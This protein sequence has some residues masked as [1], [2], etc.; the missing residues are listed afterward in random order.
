MAGLLSKFKMDKDLDHS[1]S[2]E[3]GKMK[4]TQSISP[5]LTLKGCLCP[6]EK[7]PDPGLMEMICI[8]KRQGAGG[9]R[10]AAMENNPTLESVKKNLKAHLREK[11]TCIYEG[12]SATQSRLENIYTR[13]F[14]TQQNE[15]YGCRSHEILDQFKVP[16]KGAQ[17]FLY[18]EIDSLNIFKQGRNFFQQQPAP[19][20]SIQR[21]MTKGIAGI[22]KTVAVQNF[23]LHWAQ[24]KSNQHIDFIFVL[25][26]RELN[27]LKEGEYTLLEL[28]LH[29]YPELRPLKDAQKLPQKQVLFILDG[30]D[31]SRFSLDFEGAMTITNPDQ[32]ATVNVLLTNLLKGNL[33]PDAL[34][35]I[36]SRPAAAG[37][38]PSKYI[39]QMTE[40]QGFT[41]QH[42]EEYFKK[43]FNSAGQA[44]E[45]LD[46]LRGMIS[47]Y[48][49][50]HIPIFCWI[51]AEV[52]KTGWSD[53]RSRRITTMTELYIYYLI[54]QTQR[55]AQKYGQK[56]R[57]KKSTKDAAMILNLSKL[58]F[59]QL[60]KGNIIFYEEDLQECGIDLDKASEFCGFCSEI[61]K[62]ERGL[63]ETKMFSF[64]HLSFQE[65]LAALFVFHCCVTKDVSP[66]KSF[67]QVDPTEL[68]LLELQKRVV[69]QA[70]KSEKGQLDLFLCF[71]LGF[72]LESNQKM[73]QDLLPQ[74]K[75]SSE[76]VEE[77]KKYL[78]NFHA[79]N[80]PQERCMNLLLCKFELK[81]ERFQDDI[82]RF[83]DAG[84]RLSPIDCAVLSTMLQISGE[85]VEEINL[86]KCFTPIYGIEKLVRAMAR[87]KRA[88]LKS[89]Q[90]KEECLEI[91]FSILLSSDSYLRELH[92]VCVYNVDTPP[93]HDLLG[94]LDG[95]DCKLET[96]RLSGFTLDFRHCHSLASTLQSKQ[97][98]LRTLDLIDCIY[99][100]PHDYSGYYSK[101]VEEKK[102]YE[103]LI[104][105][106]TLLT[107]IPAGLIG[108]VCKL[109][110]FSMP[111]CHLK[112]KCCQVFAS[113]LSSNSQLRELDLSRNDLQ[114]L[115]VQLLST[116]LGS[117]KCRLEI[118]RLL[119]CGITEEGCA[120]LA[121]A[122]KSNPSHL[123]ELDLSYNHP[124]EAGVRLL[125]ERLE[126][127][128]C[129]L[130]KLNVDHDEE[131][132]VNLQLLNKYACNLTLD[133]NTVHENLLLS[134]CKKKVDFT[135]EK[136]PHPDHPDRF[137]II[138][139]VLC[140]E[141]L[142]GRCYWEVEW[143]GFLHVG[144]AYKSIERKGHMNPD[145]LSSGK[146]WSCALMSSDGYSFFH[147]QRQW[148]I[149]VPFIDVKAFLA[150]R[151]RFG[152]FLDWPAG[153]LSFYSLSGD[154]K[155]HLHTFN[156][157]FTEPLYPAFT[158]VVGSLTIS[159]TGMP[160]MDNA[161]SSFTPEV[162]TERLSISYRFKFPCSGV[163]EC[164][165]TGLMFNVT[166]EGEVTYKTLIWDN[167]L[168]EPAG[169]VPGGPLFSIKSPQDLICQLHLPHCEP[170]PGLVSESIS[171]VHITDEGMSIIQPLEITETHVVVKTPHLSAFGIILDVIK[172][173]KDFM[174][175]PVRGQILLFSRPAYK[176]MHVILSVILLPSNV[177]LQEVKA[178]YEKSMYIQ[179]PSYCCLHVNQL[180]SLH[181]NPEGFTIQPPCAQ[182]F[183]NYGPNFHAS[184]EITLT[185]STEEVT[186][187]VQDPDKTPVWEH[188][189]NLP[190]SSTDTSP[191][192]NQP[193]MRS[194]ASA[195]EKLHRAR[196]RFIDRASDPLLNKLLD[197]L[198]QCEV[199]NDA[200]GEAARIKPRA[201][202]ARDVI[203]M[204]RK[205]G[206]KASAKLIAIFSNND[207]FLSKE[208]K[209]T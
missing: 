70:L 152:L 38:I 182:F 53:Q 14:I 201:E 181:S 3:D 184:F 164:S 196:P 203:D 76:T 168:L 63:Y 150:R 29:F 118:L 192:E 84:A 101:E 129:R 49:M 16:N 58:A 62:Q 112:N 41:E 27:M 36:T 92:L 124:G 161:K 195:V 104:D 179:A 50:G 103:D 159:S 90:L 187:M 125:S 25:P 91:L 59:E 166:H 22:G 71:F 17:P 127:P 78:R 30:L 147:G 110:E 172:R 120:S 47:F 87:C 74:T 137:D 117:L 93:H 209:L 167:K 82:R 197:E 4:S 69:D 116:G 102:E 108:P 96:L 115:G 109:R 188:G 207:P 141:G 21:V 2:E 6:S 170:E 98:S 68:G 111:G 89:D 13:L 206:A 123:R 200:E 24:G 154:K 185:T 19:H 9:F 180:Y 204:V 52:F 142:T 46:H 131:L 149:P 163:F 95:P 136:Q 18:E 193:M 45:V 198:L 20:K 80:L 66:L 77:V 151:R 139:Q 122:L 183:E 121:L 65:F 205:K 107:F 113:V 43:R 99:S 57:K 156:A 86:E 132:W 191:D 64:V 177:P 33:L 169:K 157:T 130:E 199:L 133:S 32:H 148:F 174:T 105:E 8:P 67:L 114:D 158:V 79:G 189:L 60:Q 83:L 144:V 178:Q 75:S 10:A 72:S 26:F 119:H 160:A 73:L 176:K 153:T 85:L 106:L 135:E 31:E 5:P 48:F 173:F 194:S 165:L 23:S 140:E 34:L 11:F 1:D 128:E 208:L 55:T 61:L 54:I 56:A 138:T 100:Y 134:D 42:K 126:D 175:T 81:E 7:W 40:V 51:I 44:K 155:T 171:V 202:K 190:A 12:T 143:E 186:L 97:T 146:A 88:V 28:L 39:D 35:W 94:V 15:D 145:I 37:Q 162:V